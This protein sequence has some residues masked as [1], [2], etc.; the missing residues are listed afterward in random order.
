MKN[1]AGAR[2]IIFLCAGGEIGFVPNESLTYKKNTSTGD[3]YGHEFPNFCEI[4][5]G[6][7]YSAFTKKCCCC[8]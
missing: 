6:K 2:C 1:G 7:T 8:D 4:D 3:Y 5:E